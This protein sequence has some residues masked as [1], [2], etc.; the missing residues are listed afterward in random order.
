MFHLKF[1]KIIKQNKG[2]LRRDFLFGSLN[3][4]LLQGVYRSDDLDREHFEKTIFL[5]NCY[6]Q[7]QGISCTSD[8]L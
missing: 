8:I 5:A 7:T 3:F 4:P 2:Q 6:N 1:K